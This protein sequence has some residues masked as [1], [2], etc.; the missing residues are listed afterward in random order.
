MIEITAI[1]IK[2]AAMKNGTT[3][4]PSLNWGPV[5]ILILLPCVMFWMRPII[6]P[7][8]LRLHA[9]RD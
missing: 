4:F 2:I 1:N 6:T 7:N 8:V 9:V 5:E 3:A